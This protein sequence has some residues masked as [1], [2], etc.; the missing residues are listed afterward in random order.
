MNIEWKIEAM[1]VRPVLDAYEN[2]VIT[3]YWRANGTDGDYSA[4]VCG[5]ITLEEPGVPFVEYENLTEAQVIGWVKDAM[6]EDQ[7]EAHEAGLAQR[8]DEQINP[9]VLRP[10]LPW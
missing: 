2:V 8:I 6:G 4:S 5:T 3:A 9:P 10:A 1:D 7:V